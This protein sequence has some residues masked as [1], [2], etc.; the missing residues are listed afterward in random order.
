MVAPSCD[1]QPPP[2]TQHPNMG[3]RM[4]PT[5]SSHSRNAQNVMR[6]QIAPTMMY[7][8]VSMNTTSNS[9]RTLLPAS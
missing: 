6:S 7:P 1:I 9:V 5:K 8:A 3:Y 2:Q 4:A